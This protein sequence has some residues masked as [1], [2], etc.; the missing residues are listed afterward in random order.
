MHVSSSSKLS[1]GY[2]ADQAF[3]K[4]IIDKMGLMEQI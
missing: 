1:T 4:A 2:L 3:A